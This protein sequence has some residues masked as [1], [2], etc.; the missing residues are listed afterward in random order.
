MRAVQARSTDYTRL[1]HLDELVQR[2][3]SGGVSVDEAHDAMDEL[4][5]Q[6]HPYPRWVATAGW[7]GFALGIAMLLGGSWLTWILAAITSVLIDRTLR[8]LNRLGTPTFFQQAAGAAIATLVAVGAYLFAGVGPSALVATGIVMLLA[9]M[10][11]VGSVQDAL[12]G[13]MVT[14]VARLGTCCS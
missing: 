11:L 1:A 6:P 4:S 9:G 10:T 13:Y 2:I 5:E 3:T 7:A 14:A 8:W 12:T